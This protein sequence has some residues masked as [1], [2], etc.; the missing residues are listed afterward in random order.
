MRRPFDRRAPRIHPEAILLEPCVVAGDV[1]IGPET[2]VWFGAVIRGD[3]GAVRI[4]ARSNIQDNCVLHEST[5]RTPLVIEDEVTVGHGAI[6]HGCHLKK[7]CLVGM[8]AVVLDE[9]V[10]GQEAM[11]GAGALVP[12]GMVIPDRHLAVGVPAKVRRPLTEAEVAAL[13]ES[14]EHYVEAAREYQRELEG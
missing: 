11:V 12:E 8:G 6:L 5:R 10:V 7:R 13:Q 9:A 2:S 3:V 1:E 14:A 4:G